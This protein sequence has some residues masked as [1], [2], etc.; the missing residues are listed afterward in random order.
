MMNILKLSVLFT[1]LLSGS[2]HAV[3]IDFD[4]AAYAIPGSQLAAD[5]NGVDGW[6]SQSFLGFVVPTPGIGTN[7]ALGF[8][9]KYVLPDSASESIKRDVNFALTGN[10]T[11]VH[12]ASGTFTADVLV[13]A[14]VN[15]LEMMFLVSPS[16]A[17]LVMRPWVLHLIL[18]TLSQV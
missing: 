6:E 13:N 16:T 15:A 3:T 18:V 11:G 5:A 8:G 4:S 2:L 1:L 10:T 12:S 17:T 9:P 7:Q 14:P